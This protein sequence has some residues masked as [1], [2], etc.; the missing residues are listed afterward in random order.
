MDEQ[1]GADAFCA[2]YTNDEPKEMSCDDCTYEFETAEGCEC[3]MDEQCEPIKLL[4]DGCT[5]CQEGIGAFCYKKMTG[6]DLEEPEEPEMTCEEC[7]SKFASAGGCE[8]MMDD[9]CVPIT[10]LPDGCT[11][12]MEHIGG[13]CQ[14]EMAGKH[15]EQPEPEDTLCVGDSSTFNAGWGGCDTYA[16]TNHNFCS[17]DSDGTNYA[18]QVCVECSRCS[19]PEPEPQEPD[20]P[21][22]PEAPEE[23][24]T[25]EEPEAPKESDAQD[26]TCFDND[27]AMAAMFKDFMNMETCAAVLNTFDCKKPFEEYTNMGYGFAFEGTPPTESLRDQG[28][29]SCSCPPAPTPQECCSK[30]WDVDGEN[31]CS[32]EYFI[33]E[34]VP[35]CGM[36][37]YD[38]QCQGFQ[39]AYDARPDPQ[40]ATGLVYCCPD[41]KRCVDQR[42]ESNHG[43]C[44]PDQQ[45]AE[46]GKYSQA[47]CGAQM[48]NDEDYP[49]KCTGLCDNPNFPQDWMA[50]MSCEG[51]Q[52]ETAK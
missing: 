1:C 35:T 32:M 27:A 24:E 21:K 33:E 18:Y 42:P 19:M 5:H 47:K 22:E 9:K 11:N 28:L 23:P 41:A 49:K 52:E 17:D 50:S 46:C 4:P 45:S 34:T 39:A 6:K 37:L 10:L 26:G 25:P 12:C 7:S 44:D 29:C 2:E 48:Q 20:A 30:D 38:R 3:M 40:Y 15:P 16:K 31:F 51:P 43:G 8:C 13:F 14:K 36:C